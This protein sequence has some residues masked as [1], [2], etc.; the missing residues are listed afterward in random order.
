[1]QAPKLG[2]VVPHRN[3]WEV[4]RRSV[5][6]LFHSCVGKRV[7]LVDDFSED[8]DL[9]GP[10]S[11][12]KSHRNE[13][14]A[15]LLK[16]NQGVQFARN[17]GYYALRRDGCEYTLFSD[18]DVIWHPGA[19]DKLVEALDRSGEAYAYCDFERGSLG[20]WVAGEW[21]EKRLRASNYISTMSVIRTE[22]LE[23]CGGHPFDENIKRL[24]DWDLWLTLLSKGFRGTYVPEVLFRT[25]FQAGGISGG[26]GYQDAVNAIVDKHK[27]L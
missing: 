5:E 12:T 19:L 23:V 6:T 15:I 25:D 21:D 14:T 13:I 24:Q 3:Q 18:S 4:F 16:P 2:I 22:A 11:L 20:T 10:L 7:V 1:M 26:L 8:E 17:I 27:P 9:L